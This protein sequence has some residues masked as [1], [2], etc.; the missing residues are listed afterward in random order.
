MT[1]RELNHNLFIVTR[2]NLRQNQPLFDAVQADLVMFPARII[3]DKIRVLLGTPIHNEFEQLSKSQ[4]DEWACELISRIVAVTSTEV[5]EVWEVQ[6]NREDTPAICNIACEEGEVTLDHIVT[7]PRE[8]TR[9]LP[10]VALLLKRDGDQ[11]LLAPG[12]D[13][14]L[15][16][17]DQLLFCGQPSAADRMEWTLQNEYA[18]NYVLTGETGPQG[19]VWRAFQRNTQPK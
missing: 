17:N 3:A 8:R 4:D 12:T 14:L 15:K 2:Q 13:T 19:L 6:L 10:C 7:D 18:L 5:P 1:A 16:E 9:K 11:T